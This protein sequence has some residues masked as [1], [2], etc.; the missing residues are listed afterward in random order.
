MKV[1]IMKFT[2][3]KNYVTEAVVAVVIAQATFPRW[4]V[5]RHEVFYSFSFGQN[6]VFCFETN[7]WNFVDFF[8][9]FS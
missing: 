6:E 4:P 5:M 9:F 7:Y 8:L 2:N 3:K 1:L